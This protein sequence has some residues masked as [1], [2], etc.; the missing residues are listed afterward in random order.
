MGII[1]LPI[2]AFA[3][4]KETLIIRT[5]ECINIFNIYIPEDTLLLD[6][7][8]VREAIY[9]T[10]GKI[11]ILTFSRLVYSQIWGI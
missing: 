1:S 5:V 9:L 6:N 7:H 3:P 4:S 10:Y 11:G 2:K 8:I